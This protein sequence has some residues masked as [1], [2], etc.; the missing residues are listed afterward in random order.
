MSDAIITE[1]WRQC[2]AWSHEAGLAKK[3]QE[4]ARLIALWF[5]FGG[6]VCGTLAGQP[7]DLFEGQ[8]T[9][10]GIVASLF[11]ALGGY[12]G[13]ELLSADKESQWSQARILA[14]ALRR[15]CWLCLMRAPPYDGAERAQELRERAAA[16]LQNL[17]LERGAVAAEAHAAI[18]EIHRVDDYIEQRALSQAAWYE[19]RAAE[20]RRQH[21]KYKGGTFVLGALA[22][23]VSVVGTSQHW[24][25]AFIPIVTTASG[26]LVAWIQGNR[27][28]ATVSLYQQTATQLRLQVAI[29]RDSVAQ[30]EA[31]PVEEQKQ[32]TG[33]LVQK[34]EAIM[35][36]ENGAWRAEW[37]NEEKA[38][39]SIAALREVT[40]G[41]KPR[42][43]VAPGG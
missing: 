35:A 18:P 41:A 37:T 21:G 16:L 22:I 40:G 9:L 2:D 19:R 17:G 31:L 26:G 20:Q 27:I 5:G 43:L 3:R 4:N 28:G 14:E 11:V 24:L 32:A 1:V 15:E 39:K 6:A 8:R 42:A 30:R 12:F 23:G 29:W 38:Q 36:Q 10:L 25:L 34:C 7:E 13:R 33:N